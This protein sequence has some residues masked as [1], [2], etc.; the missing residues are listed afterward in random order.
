MRPKFAFGL[1]GV[2]FT[3]VIPLLLV[4]L[5][6][7]DSVA[8]G[9]WRSTGIL[10]LGLG[11]AL[12]LNAVDMLTSRTRAFLRAPR[13]TERDRSRSCSRD[14]DNERERERSNSEIV[15][16]CACFELCASADVLSERAGRAEEDVLARFERGRGD[17]GGVTE[18]SD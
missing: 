10:V 17:G 7:F 18:E 1:T 8:A 13:L 5:D 3:S 4:S 14:M 12:S 6:F 9:R 11:F 16:A 15:C 2:A